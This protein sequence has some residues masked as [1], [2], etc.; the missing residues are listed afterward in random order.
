MNRRVFRGQ[1]GFLGR[2]LGGW[3]FAPIFTAASGLPIQLVHSNG[4]AQAFGE[5]DGVNFAV[6]PGE[7]GVIIGNPQASALRATTA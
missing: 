4:S 3:T 5:G 6:Q 7:N 2:V 1:H